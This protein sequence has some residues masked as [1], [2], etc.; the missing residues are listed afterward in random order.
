[1]HRITMKTNIRDDDDGG[2]GDGGLVR[3]RE[4]ES[5]KE[6]PFPKYKINILCEFI[7]HT[8]FLFLCA[9]TTTT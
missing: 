2:A 4:R 1:M 3:E 9:T 8:N 5:L 6:N 7:L